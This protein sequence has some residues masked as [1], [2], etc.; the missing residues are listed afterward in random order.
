MTEAVN[1]TAPVTEWQI[2]EKLSALH[3]LWQMYEHILTETDR[4]DLAEQIGSL[5]LE[6]AARV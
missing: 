1:T 4:F 5:V 2:D 6:K 3:T